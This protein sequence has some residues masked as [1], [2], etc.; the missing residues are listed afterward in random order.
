MTVPPLTA[1][2]G[3]DH[4]VL[5]VTDL[6]AAEALWRRLGFT[7]TPRGFHA[8]R[9]SANHTTPFRSGTYLELIYIPP[10]VDTAP[11][12]DKPSG[13]MAVALNTADGWALNA[14]IG[15]RGFVVDPPRDLSRPVQVG[16]EIRDA[17][18]LTVPMP[19]VGLGELGLFA[20]VHVTPDLVWRP[21]WQ[22][23]ANGVVGLEGLVAV[24][25]FP[26]RFAGAYAT[27]FGDAAVTTGPDGM[28]VN[29]GRGVL[30]ILTPG[31]WATRFPGV[32]VAGDMTAGTLAGVTLRAEI[33][34]TEA[35][36]AASGIAARRLPD[37]RLLLDPAVTGGSLLE[38]RPV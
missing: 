24:A 27:L 37:G 20:C 6:D 13:P 34:R 9:G 19:H 36:L 15:A 8:G 25:E 28:T 23:H 3:I 11:Y 14:E 31:A 2:V 16:A 26:C 1:L 35:A 38:F 5:R 33:A 7:L 10:G 30:E 17:R 29:F 12:G 4:A 22:D 21:E 32:T 18:F